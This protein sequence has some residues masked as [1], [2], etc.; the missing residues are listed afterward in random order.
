MAKIY[1]KSRGDVMEWN[2]GRVTEL[3]KAVLLFGSMDYVQKIKL[4]NGSNVYVVSEKFYQN[5]CVN[6]AQKQ[7]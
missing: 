6:G 3:L 2:E 7:V 4:D 5:V 1:K